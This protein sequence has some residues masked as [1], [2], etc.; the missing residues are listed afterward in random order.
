MVLLVVGVHCAAEDEHGAVG[1][2][3]PRRR[4]APAEA[5]LLQLVSP[6][7]DGLGEDSRADV[8]A[9]DHREHVHRGTLP[10]RKK[11]PPEGGPK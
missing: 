1:V 8:V 10:S 4:R 5:P 11:G 6:L 3:R 9:V 7:G 2:E